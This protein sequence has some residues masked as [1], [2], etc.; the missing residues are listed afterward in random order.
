M[1]KSRWRFAHYRLNSA[2]KQTP[3]KELIVFNKDTTCVKCKYHQSLEPNNVL[4]LKSYFCDMHY[5][6][7]FGH[8]YYYYYCLNKKT[9]TQRSPVVSLGR[10]VPYFVFIDLLFHLASQ[11]NYRHQISLN[12][13]LFCAKLSRKIGC[14]KS[15]QMHTSHL[16][17]KDGTSYYIKCC[18]TVTLIKCH[19]QP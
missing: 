8:Y 6:K 14:P 16:A 19:Q 10:V 1:S 9:L 3:T 5:N 18:K 12:P 2:H 17:N 11:K 4:Y 15:C 13:R 7:I